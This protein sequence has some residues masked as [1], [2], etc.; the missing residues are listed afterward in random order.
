[1]CSDHSQFTAGGSVSNHSFGRGLDIA[2]IDG[3][4]VSPGSALA[5]EVASEL[6][7]LD[8]R[9]PARR[10]RLPVR[11]QRAR[12]TSPT[13]RTR[14]TSTSASSRRSRRTS[15]SRP[16]WPPAR[17]RPRRR[18]PS[19]P[20]SRRAGGAGRAR[21]GGVAPAATAPPPVP[22]GAPGAHLAGA[23][24]RRRRRAARG[25]SPRCA[26][27][28]KVAAAEAADAQKPRTGSGLFA[29][30]GG[31]QAQPGRTADV[32][33]RRAPSPPGA[34]PVDL[35][36]AP[37]AYPGDDAPKPQIA[38]WMAAEA[39]KRGLPAQLP[40]MAAL[41]ESN[42][43]NVDYGD[44]DSLGYFQ[45]R[46][47]IW[48]RDY[49]GFGKDPDKQTRL[50]PRHR[51]RR[52]GATRRPRPID[53]RPQPVRRMDRRHRTPRRAIPRPLPTPPRRSQQA[54]R[55]RPQDPRPPP[56]RRP[57][58]A[59][60]PRARGSH[61]API[62]PD[63]FGQEGTGGAPG[64]R[65]AGAAEEQEHRAR[66]RRRRRHQGRPDRP[67]DRGGADQAQP[68]AQDR[69]LLHVQ[70]P[71]APDRGRLGLQ[72]HVRPRASTSP[73]STARSSAPARALAR[74]VASEL[75]QFDSSIR[76]ER[77]R[78]AVPDQRARPTSPTPRT[79]T[80][81]TSGST[82]RSRPTSSRRPGWRPGRSSRPP[83]KPHPS[84]RPARRAG[85]CSGGRGWKLAR[86][87]GAARRSDPARGSRDRGRQHGPAGRPVSRGGGGRA[88]EPVVRVVH[89]LVA[90]AGRAQDGR[91]AA[92]PPSRR[93]CATPSRAATASSS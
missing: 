36:G 39:K 24:G 48:E 72:P 68:G 19:P 50:V 80:T 60:S 86:R 15:S 63:Q 58:A 41:V 71:L 5:R 92:G 1:M 42:L 74:E 61:G 87:R 85:A 90:G 33:R 3:E 32:A 43:T 11:D 9:D 64:S 52:Q 18:P 55:R 30:V 54:A 17:S 91:A 79:P 27:P 53:R 10:D 37:G 75:S 57:A 66:R 16:S 65:G 77:D 26:K 12:A 45:M 22:G 47:S 51:R 44:A 88:R 4:I 40:V 35:T 6:S 82:P 38:A 69:R 56:P 23:G 25:C 70:R 59:A 8:T 83:P 62:D 67:A 2:S 93:G 81:S 34:V 29:A 78:L 46:V 89:H 28:A 76:P 14:T 20:R 73:R 7:D 21:A 84:S 49:P 13:P 31:D